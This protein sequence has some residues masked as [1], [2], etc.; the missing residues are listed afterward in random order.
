MTIK[1]HLQPFWQDRV[2]GV[3]GDFDCDK[4]NDFNCAESRHTESLTSPDGQICPADGNTQVPGEPCPG[5]SGKYCRGICEKHSQECYIEC[6]DYDTGDADSNPS[7]C[8]ITPNQSTSNSDDSTCPTAIEDG[9]DNLIDNL[10]S[11]WNACKADTDATNDIKNACKFEACIWAGDT[12][13]TEMISHVHKE[14]LDAFITSCSKRDSQIDTCSLTIDQCGD[15]STF[16]QCSTCAQRKTCE[17]Y[18]DEQD[19]LVV[20]CDDSVTVAS[21]TCATDYYLDGDTCTHKDNCTRQTCTWTE[22]ANWSSCS[23]TCGTGAGVQTRVRTGN[24]ACTEEN[25]Q[26][27]NCTGSGDSCCGTCQPWAE[28]GTCNVTCGIGT[29]SRNR[30]CGPDQACSDAVQNRSCDS[31]V[32]CP[33]CTSCQDWTEWSACSATCG[34]G[35]RTRT[36]SCGDANCSDNTQ[37]ENCNTDNCP[38]VCDTDCNTWGSWSSCS[39]T[40]GGGT[41]TRTRSCSGSAQNACQASENKNCGMDTCPPDTCIPCS[42]ANGAWTEW[43]H[44]S[45]TCGGGTQTRFR[46]L[47]GPN[48]NPEEELRICS[49]NTCGCT[50]CDECCDTWSA[51]GH[52]SAT[53]DGSQTRTRSCGLYLGCPDSDSQVSSFFI[54]CELGVGFLFVRTSDQIY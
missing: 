5:N 32:T 33:D 9:C 2:Q 51:W 23:V 43:G 25:I 34:T 19:G 50:S 38:I 36:Q 24:D 11:E 28:W 52:C 27:Q 47:C 40:C 26:T 53:C 54:S 16:N 35:T 49:T 46:M 22:W 8:S 12:D 48:C 29:Q 41:S 18:L 15:N 39:T 10:G 17:D 1:T 42:G 4:D 6:R 13:E 20:T 21:C 37:S 44:C 30:S 3:C 45:K 14:T 31:D 7:Q